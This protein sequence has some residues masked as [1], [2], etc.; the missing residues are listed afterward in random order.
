MENWNKFEFIE[1]IKYQLFIK[2]HVICVF[3]NKNSICTNMYTDIILYRIKI[4]S[5]NHQIS[6]IKYLIN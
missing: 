3:S 1:H 2:K 4:L 6:K 5:T